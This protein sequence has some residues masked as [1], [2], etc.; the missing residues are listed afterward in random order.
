MR[1]E[2]TIHSEKEGGF[3]VHIPAFALWT[4]GETL[5]ECQTMAVD[6]V[7]SALESE[8]T[9]AGLSFSDKVFAFAENEKQFTI[10]LPTREG[11]MLMV[12]QLRQETGLSLAE[13]TKATGNKSKNAT[14]QYEKGRR[15]PGVQKLEELLGALGMDLVIGFRQKA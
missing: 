12:K 4:Q 2:A 15:E 10:K 11:V 13:M 3:S 8:S 5:E 9:N 14:L 1:V 7:V 6:A